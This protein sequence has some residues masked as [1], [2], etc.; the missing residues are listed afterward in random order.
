MEFG[1]LNMLKL[2]IS[3][4][5]GDMRGGEFC[6]GI[7]VGYLYSMIFGDYGMSEDEDG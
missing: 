6:S 1:N 4:D 5:R 3:W 7:H 2:Q